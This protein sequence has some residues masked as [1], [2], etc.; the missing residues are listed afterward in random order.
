MTD[1]ELDTFY[2]SLCATM[3]QLGESQ[4]PLFLARLSLLAVSE[5]PD[6]RKAMHLI[7]A[8]AEGLVASTAR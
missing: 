7:D 4:A 3:S 6:S 2:S 1:S 8:A 5:L